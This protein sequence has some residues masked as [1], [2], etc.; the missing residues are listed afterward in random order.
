MKSICAWCK[1][2]MGTVHSDSYAESIITH[3]ICEECAHIAFAELNMDRM[4][5]FIDRLP[6]P[7]LVVDRDVVALMANM[8]AKEV[9]GKDLPQIKG[10]KGGNIIECV[11]ANEPGG[12]GRTTHCNG[13]AIRLTVEDT[14]KTGKSH[15][16]VP[17]Y[18]DI[19]VEGKPKKIS[20]LISTKKVKGVV[21]LR[22]DKVGDYEMW[23]NP[24][25]T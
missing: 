17:A 21:L 2:D 14:Y 5:I 13:C 1:K 22:I 16:R 6:E 15:L 3:G 20:F 12:C 10:F 18:A 8:K 11:H 25:K 9:L 4:A 23:L 24:D 7:V 19:P